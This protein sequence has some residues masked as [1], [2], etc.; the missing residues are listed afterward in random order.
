MKKRILAFGTALMCLF[1]FSACDSTQKSSDGSNHAQT[2][3]T[4]LEK[5]NE[6]KQIDS[7]IKITAKAEIAGQAQEFAVD[8]ALQANIEDKRNLQYITQG[9]VK[10]SG[11]EM[12]FLSAYKDGYMYTKAMGIKA[13]QKVS[14][15]TARNDASL[16][17][18]PE[19]TADMIQSIDVKKDGDNTVYVFEIDP[20]KADE[21]VKSIRKS[22]DSYAGDSSGAGDN[23]GMNFNS[24]SGEIVVDS[25]GYVTKNMLNMGVDTTEDNQKTAMTINMEIV[26][27]NPGKEVKIDF[28]DDLNAYTEQ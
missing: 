14:A 7:T 21:L 27:K 5:Q 12:G 11:L 3:M 22:M 20:Q 9:S 17:I 6:M 2:L 28:P 26:Y 1:I 10:F 4:A 25:N 16:D 18:Q 13:K 19:I 15:S 23:V 24:I 8:M